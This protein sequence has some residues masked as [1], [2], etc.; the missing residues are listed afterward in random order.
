MRIKKRGQ[1]RDSVNLSSVEA[2]LHEL[3]KFSEEFDASDPG[4]CEV[5][6]SEHISKLIS[7]GI[8]KKRWFKRVKRLDD[9][10]EIIFNYHITDDLIE[11]VREFQDLTN[12]YRGEPSLEDMEEARVLLDKIVKNTEAYVETAKAKHKKS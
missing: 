6:L 3:K 7:T 12:D 5:L 9:V 8:I 2:L 10:F 11:T 1:K 4:L